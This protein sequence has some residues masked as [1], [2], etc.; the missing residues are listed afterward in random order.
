M[1]DIFWRRWFRGR[2]KAEIDAYE[3][4][5]FHLI[6][7]ALASPGGQELIA[8]LIERHHILTPTVGVSEPASPEEA[9]RREGARRVVLQILD[10]ARVK[11]A[12]F[13]ALSATT[14][15]KEIFNGG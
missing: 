1:A 10:M 11:P 9:H 3:S 15:T 7:A 6:R 12:T 8:L 5:R 2:P 14:D 4:Q 13:A